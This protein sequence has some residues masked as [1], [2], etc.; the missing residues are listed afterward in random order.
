MRKI[1]ALLLCFALIL[2]FA[3]PAKAETAPVESTNTAAEKTEILS[4]RD[5]YSKT[6]Q[7]PDGTYQYVVR[8]APVHYL[9]SAGDYAEINNEITAAA[10]RDGYTYTNTANAWNAFFAN[11]LGGDNAVMMEYGK[12]SISFSLVGQTGTAGVVKA[13]DLAA[14]KD[15]LS[16]Y[17]QKLSADDRA[18]LYRDVA[19][20]VDISYT[21]T[22]GTLKEDIILKSKNA[23]SSFKFRLTANGLT[24]KEKDDTIALVTASGEEVFTFAPL[25]MV[26]ANGKRSEEVSLTYAS[27]KNGYELTVSADPEF[28]NAKDTAYPV[29]IDPSINV[30]GYAVTYDTYVNQASP[31]TNYN[32][33]GIA[34]TL[35]TGGT[36]GTDAMHTYLKFHLN[37]NLFATQVDDAHIYVA[38]S[39]GQTP[40]IRAY[41]ATSSWDP[42]TLKWNNKPAYDAE[43][44]SPVAAAGQGSYYKL[45]VK[46]LVKDW[47]DPTAG[48][49]NHGVV[50]KEADNVPSAQKTGFY[51][52]DSNSGWEP[53]LVINYHYY[54]SRPYLEI[55]STNSS[56]YSGV[57]S[58][59]YALELNQNLD[60]DAISLF[61]E[62]MFGMTLEDMQ[63]HAWERIYASLNLH[64]GQNAWLDI[65][66]HSS[67]IDFGSFRAFCQIGF[68]N[69]EDDTD[70]IFDSDDQ[71]D[72]RW[73]YQTDEGKWAEKVGSLSYEYEVTTDFGPAGL[74]WGSDALLSN[75]ICFYFQVDDIR[76]LS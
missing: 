44:V 30:T 23:P 39:T 49:A 43:D 34:N 19:E 42:S 6:Y 31:N 45:N 20:N 37:T 4:L 53:E 52:S 51:S 27:V 11:K 47:L 18:V 35:W 24:I 36:L 38:K 67:Y 68:V 55:D 62:N 60:L 54:S 14:S 69:S 74:P 33:S 22:T 75:S 7:L 17:H 70:N 28:L 61:E 58:M 1:V 72:W 26:D 41:R 9:D 21:V 57:S 73:M 2:P 59:G 65:P 71:F 8:T 66:A 46:D 50:L 56:S 40:N 76:N 12:Y 32:S 25:F 48:I 29:V 15:T 10:K 5:T 63:S 3:P 64:L 16:T 13:T